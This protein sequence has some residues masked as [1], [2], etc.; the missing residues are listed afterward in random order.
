MVFLELEICHDILMEWRHEAENSFLYSDPC[1]M[2]GRILISISETIGGNQ[3]L[4]YFILLFLQGFPR[5]QE[6]PAAALQKEHKE[7]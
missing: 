7:E 2:F 5:E 6:A 3:F 1:C 4:A